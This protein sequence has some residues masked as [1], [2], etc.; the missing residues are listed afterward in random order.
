MKRINLITPKKYF[1]VP[2]L[3]QKK[4]V[5]ALL[6]LF[7][8]VTGFKYYKLQS[9]LKIETQS[10]ANLET[11]IQRL[12][13]TLS[14]KRAFDE[15]ARYIEKEFADISADYNILK[16]NLIIKDLMVKL[17]EVIPH[18]TWIT[19]LD[20]VYEGEKKLSISGK[21]INKEEVFTFLNNLSSV[22]KNPELTGMTRE[23]E[24]AQFSFQIT[25][26]LI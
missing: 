14:E 16:K 2:V 10:I 9:E 17:A 24:K 7:F 12:K 23:G 3:L 26:E 25:V 19:S 4:V 21:S 8:V 6:I 1:P 13:L 18:N 11:E 5:A 20:L 22:G 15:K